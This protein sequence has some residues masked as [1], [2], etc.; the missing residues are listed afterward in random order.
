MTSQEH[1]EKQIR[2]FLVVDE[3]LNTEITITLGDTSFKSPI[4]RIKSLLEFGTANHIMRRFIDCP[5]GKHEPYPE[6]YY[7]S[8]WVC[9]ELVFAAQH[10]EFKSK[11]I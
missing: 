3:F 8:C 5:A 7:P 4:R 11:F 9:G 10:E 1:Q 6:Y 2:D